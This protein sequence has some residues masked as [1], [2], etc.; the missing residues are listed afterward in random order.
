MLSARGYLWTFFCSTAAI[1]LIGS[2]AGNYLP[3]RFGSYVP[4]LTRDE[5]VR[6]HAIKETRA[7]CLALFGDSRVAFNISASIIDQS[8][9]QNCSSQNYGFPGID[10]SVIKYLSHSVSPRLAVISVSEPMLTIPSEPPGIIQSLQKWRTQFIRDV[11]KIGAFRTLYLGFSRF[12][13]L[14]RAIEA[15]L[16]DGWDWSRTQKRWLSSSIEKR[17][18]VSLPS[19]KAESADMAANYFA[20]N[21]A[22]LSEELS[23][24]IDSLRSKGAMVAIL[25]PPSELSFQMQPISARQRDR[26]QITRDVAMELNA[27]I[28]DCSNA[29][30][31][32]IKPSGFA[33]PV[34]L[35]DSGVSDYSNYLA[36]T[37]SGM[38]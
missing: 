20:G 24:L 35:N 10:L 21:E 38:L 25:I 37:I 18:L 23:S 15:P 14:L 9:P 7:P 5:F 19:Y 1:L 28:I 6:E 30:S 4:P 3:G 34:H 8:L 32:G 33:D 29:A 17:E 11:L 26:W 36:S 16:S 31:C 22:G 27:P 12:S 2:I 13:Q